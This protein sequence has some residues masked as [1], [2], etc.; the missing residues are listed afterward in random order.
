M[1]LLEKKT[2]VALSV[3]IV[4]LIIVAVVAI[5]LTQPKAPIETGT[6]TSPAQAGYYIK[7]PSGSPTGTYYPALTA[8]ASIVSKYNPDIVAVAIPG[9]G[10][11][12]N[13]RSVGSGEYPISLSTSMVAYFAYTG[14][15]PFEG[16]A[17]PDLRA[18]GPAHPL[19]ISFIVKADSGIKTIYDLEGK[20]IA[21]G[22]AG[23]GDAVAAEILL[24]EA[25]IWDKVVKVNVGDPESW[26]MLKVGTVDAAIHHTVAGNPNLYEI[27]TSTPIRLVEIPDDLA[28]K[29]INKYP[30]FMRY[31]AKAGTYNGMDEDVKVVANPSIIITNANVPE[32]LVYRFIK[33]Y[34]EHFDE[35]VQ[36]ASFLSTVDRENPLGGISIPLHPGAYKYW[37]E[38]GVQ[39]PENLKPP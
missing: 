14:T 11:A 2:L 28:E 23:S 10:S 24:K 16:E 3:I 25:G 30:Y 20:R 37:Q 1:L 5:Y 4:I 8:I 17:Y 15:G 29:L 19:V 18:V 34:W 13:C 33:T 6:T 38:V 26:N 31:V 36:A 9:G 39:V 12:S 32:D 21:I 35:V 27:S 22:E 7:M